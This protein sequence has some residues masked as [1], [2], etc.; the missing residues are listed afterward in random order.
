MAAGLAARVRERYGV[1]CDLVA[2]GGGVFE[3]TVD[4]ELIFSKRELGR[5]PEDAEIFEALDAR[6]SG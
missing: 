2:S 4:G 1:E 3:V 6:G 5:F